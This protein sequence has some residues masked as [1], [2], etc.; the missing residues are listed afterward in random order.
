LRAPS[1]VCGRVVDQA[2]GEVLSLIEG[3]SMAFTLPAEEADSGRF[4]ITLHDWARTTGVMPSC[5]DAMDGRVRVNVGDWVSNVALMDSQGQVMDQMVGGEGQIEFTASPGEYHVIV[6]AAGGV[7]PKVQRQVV[8]P[9]GEEPEVLG[10]DWTTP[11]CNE[12]EVDVEFELYGGGTFHWVL[13]D[14]AGAVVREGSGLGEF[15]ETGLAVDD[16]TLEVSH[17]CLFESHSI[18]AFDAHVPVPEAEFNPVVVM[19]EDGQAMWQAICTNSDLERCRWGLPDG[20][21]IESPFLE[22][23]TDVPGQHEV[24]LEVL[25]NGCMATRPFSFSVVSTSR[26]E[27]IPDWEVARSDGHWVLSTTYSLGP[28]N[29]SL[30]DASGRLMDRGLIE[31]P[32]SGRI[33]FPAAQ[34]V[35]WVMPHE[36]GFMSPLP[37]FRH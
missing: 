30:I 27:E 8:V 22:W 35:F 11:V 21:W 4:M 19:D 32:G 31:T 3:E 6:T 18:P 29:W 24:L 7:C 2:T 13:T 10:L 23:T 5:P 34:G 37:V 16:Y 15:R 28:V 25:A 1:E 12:G 26:M 33:K 17:D 14:G 36:A 9:E 20:T